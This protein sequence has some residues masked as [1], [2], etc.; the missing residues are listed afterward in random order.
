MDLMQG[1]SASYIFHAVP[2]SPSLVHLELKLVKNA[3]RIIWY[4]GWIPSEETTDIT[5]VH[6]AKEVKE[7]SRADLIK[8]GTEK[9]NWK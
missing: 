8:N 3:E 7:K 6:L 4:V 1:V 5:I 9:M 2:A